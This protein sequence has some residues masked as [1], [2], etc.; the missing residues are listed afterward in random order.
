MVGTEVGA[1]VEGME[2]VGASVEGMEEV[3]LWEGL[4]EG[5]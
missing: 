2:E 3:G 1:S 4:S 5:T